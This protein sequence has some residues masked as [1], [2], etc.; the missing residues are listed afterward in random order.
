[1]LPMCWLIQIVVLF[2]ADGHHKLIRW[3]F[4][5]HAGI[6]GYSRMIV[7]MRC[8]SNNRSSTVLSAFLEG[9]Q[10][11]GIPSRVRCDRGGE[12]MH[13][14]QYMLHNRGADRNSIIVGSSTHNQR[15]ERLWR[16]FHAC[17]TKLY[18]RLFY[19]LESRGLLDHTNAVCLY[20]L[21]YVFLPRINHAIDC[22]LEG[23]NNHG[24]RTAQHLSPQQLFTQGVLHLQHSGMVALDFMDKVD[25]SYGVD[26]DGPIP[27][28]EGPLAVRVP[29]NS[30][31]LSEEMLAQLR[32]TVDPLA[33]SSNYGIEL[34]EETLALLSQ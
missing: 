1:M 26:R 24:I 31:H 30:L 25:Q 21:E 15:I 9:V 18:Y 22:F 2:Y 32:A 5:T 17:V 29:E 23:W 33:E 10:R 4:V 11:F 7:Y 16:D 3:R 20:A 12:N 14:A 28:G 13:V 6:D 34:Y 8:S 19:F 27:L